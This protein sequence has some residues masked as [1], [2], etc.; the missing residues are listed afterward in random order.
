M[1][2]SLSRPVLA[3]ST[4]VP[5][6]QDH[7]HLIDRYEIKSGRRA[8][9]LFTN[10]KPYLRRDVVA[11]ADSLRNDRY[12]R[13]SVVD[14]ANLTYLN[15]DSWEWLREGRSARDSSLRSLGNLRRRLYARPADLYSFRNSEVELHVNPVV[16]WLAGAGQD[17]HRYSYI[18]TRG[19][20]IRGSISNRLGF[21][22]YFTDTQ[23][24]MPGYYYER[25]RRFGAVPGEGFQKPLGSDSVRDFFT[26]RGYITFNPLRPINLQFGHDKVFIGNGYRSMI[27]SDNSSPMLF[28]KVVTQIGRFQYVNLFSELINRQGADTLTYGM[29]SPKKFMAFHHLSVNIT[30]HLNIGVFEAVIHSRDRTQGYFDLAYFNPVIFYRP[31]E[32]QKNS[33]DNS[34]LGFDFH[35]NY[36]RRFQLYGQLMLDEFNIRRI[37]A[38]QGYWWGNKIGVQLGAKWID[39]LGVANLDVQLEYNQARPFT[40]QHL[41]SLTN[42]VHYN[43]SLAHPFG[44]N[45]REVLLLA[46]YQPLPRLRLTLTSLRALYGQDVAEFNFGGNPL[47]SYDDRPKRWD[48]LLY[49][50]PSPRD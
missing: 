42:Y 40:Y 8:G 20:E 16:Y 39:V 50:S 41:S 36:R 5:L 14:G 44:G 10:V 18:N 28:L 26:P 35:Y 25:I 2:L 45:F 46:R 12:A 15:D 32:Q 34:L 17:V 49:T 38:S 11:L 43:Q 6:D 47:L 19:V 7:Y 13:L 4:F 1:G 21:Y 22:T 30:N 29:L 48:C 27:L 9:G 37:R 31:V 3:Q 23:L 24:R 33:P